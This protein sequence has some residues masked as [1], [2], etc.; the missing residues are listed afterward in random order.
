MSLPCS[1]KMLG[2]QA[3]AKVGA[4]RK[5][6]SATSQ[7]KELPHDQEQATYDGRASDLGS[8]RMFELTG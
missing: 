5:S 3:A 8:A 1:G 4:L 6:G 2:R 7:A